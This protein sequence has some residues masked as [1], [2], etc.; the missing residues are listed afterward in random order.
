[1]R[2]LLTE[3]LSLSFLAGIII[4]SHNFDI[5]LLNYVRTAVFFGIL[6]YIA[7]LAACLP[8]HIIALKNE[9]LT[10]IKQP[11]VN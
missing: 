1:M 8:Y 6:L 11:R 3:Y 7:V 4:P 9:L 2:G 5:F 10:I